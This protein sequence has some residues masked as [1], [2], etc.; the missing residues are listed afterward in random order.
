MI[1]NKQLRWGFLLVVAGS[2]VYLCI[3]LTLPFLAALTWALTF[4]IVLHPLQLIVERR[5][6]SRSL[7]SLSVVGAAA[8]LFGGIAVVAG[9]QLLREA[10]GGATRVEELMRKWDTGLLEQQ[11]PR[12]AAIVQ[13]LTEKYG[14]A[15]AV[16]NIGQWFTELSTSFVLGSINQAATIVVT[17]YFLFYFLRDREQILGMVSSLLPL[18]PLEA[19]NVFA[20]IAD[21]AHATIRG[22]ILMA[23][24]QGALGG[25]M[26]RFLDLP[27]PAFWG[28]VMALLAVVP[29]L[30]AFVVWIP[31][32]L[33]LALEGEWL[34]AFVLGLWGGVVIATI[35]NLLY[36]VFVGTR[37]RLHTLVVFVGAIGGIIVFGAPGAVL[38]PVLIV[39]TQSIL[40]IVSRTAAGRTNGDSR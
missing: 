5:I 12:T 20:R 38:G 29:V 35:D 21:T 3:L 39:A 36:P 4:A 33:V 23:V 37:L 27:A 6:A 9:Q 22:T 26:F 17:F 16:G 15:D 13:W 2:G 24:V 10:A 18:D 25:L 1:W 8:F 11:F 14:P 34:A 19:K 28:L 30:G 31:A 7:A 32:A 40:E